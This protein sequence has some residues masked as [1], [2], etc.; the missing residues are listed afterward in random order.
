MKKNHLLVHFPKWK[1][2][3]IL[4]EMKLVLIL[5]WALSLSATAGVFSQNQRVSF[6]F[7]DATILEVLNEIKSQTGLSFI[8][9]EDKIQELN[10]VDVD[11]SG[12]TVGE[13][14]NEIFGDSN[15][16]CRFEEN[17]IMVVDKIP[18]PLI[19]VKQEKKEVKGK[20]TDD[21]GM[22][23]PGVSVVIKGT[24]TGVATDIDGN[25]IIEI[26]KSNVVLVFS[27]VGMLPQEIA[28]NGQ[29]VQ[30][31]TL[32]TDSE[33]MD[34]VVVVGYGSVKKE[35]IGSAISEIKS[36]E[37]EMKSIGVTNVE[38]MLGGN[39]KGLQI[40][41]GSGAPGAASTV[42]VRGITSPFTGGNNQPLY[43]VDGV[44]FNTDELLD[45]IL[46]SAGQNPL[47][48][49]APSE[50]K[51]ISVL[52]DAGATAIYGSRGANGVI[53]ITTKRGARDS[54]LSISFDA[55]MSISNP[56][57]E[58]DLLDA[59]EF[60]SLHEMVAKNTIDKFA[61]VN[62]RARGLKTAY[63]IID[64]STGQFK[65]TYFDTTLG[66]GVP[67]WGSANTDWQKEIYDENALTQKYN[68]SL[69][70]GNKKTNYAASLYYTDQDALM[71]NEYQKRY[72]AR[73]SFDTD[74]KKWLRMGA[75]L[76]V[77]G[78]KNFVGR[79]TSSGAGP[80]TEVLESRPDMPVYDELGRY[81]KQVDPIRISANKGKVTYSSLR[82]NPVAAS[83][84][85]NLT[86]SLSMF[87]NGYLE[88][89]PIKDLKLKTEL[90]VSNFISKAD[91]F[92]P[93]RALSYYSLF[94]ASLNV[95]SRSNSYNNVLST[96]L[97]FQ[98]NYLKVIGDHTIDVMAG[99]SSY[100]NRSE[101]ERSF[102]RDMADDEIMTNSDTGQHVKSSMGKGEAIMNSVYSRVQY[103]YNGKYTLT[104]NMRSDKSSKFGP[105]NKRGYFPSAAVNWNM[106]KE[107]FMNSL[108]FL[109][110]L[111][112]RASYGKTGLANI[113][114]FRFLQ[115]WSAPYNNE[116]Y[117]GK[118]ALAPETIYPNRDVKWETT[119]EFNT[120]IDFALFNNRLYGSVDYY[121]KRT[122]G[123][124]MPSPIFAESGASEI[125]DN[126]AEIS[127]EGMEF[128]LGGDIIRTKDLR[129]FASF[130]LAFNRN[131]LE[132]IKGNAISQWV[133]RNYVEG[134]PIGVINGLKIDKIIQ[135][136]QEI[137]ALNDAAPGDYYMDASTGVGDYLYVDTN[138]DG[139]IN[140]KDKTIIGTQEADFFGG[141]ST[142]LQYKNF[143]FTAGFQ[144]SVGNK[145]RWGNSS[146]LYLVPRTFANMGHD[147]L[148]NTWTKDNP[149]AK[150][151]R[152]AYGHR[153]NSLFKGMTNDEAVQDASYLRLKV[154]NLTY[155]F[156][157]SIT[158][159]LQLA[160]AAIY[161][162]GTNLLTFT[163]YKGLDPEAGGHAYAGAGDT[164]HVLGGVSG[165]DAYPMARTFTMGVKVRF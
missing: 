101:T 20:V 120:G 58:Y 123:A 60:K 96:T 22:P 26:E 153:N 33:Q 46:F 75:S 49:I 56:L 57:N 112:L 163:K 71:I 157:K 8:Y 42:R 136:Q 45:G 100:K 11:A 87:G 28:Y 130:N 16:E 102:F 84:N 66:K 48:A 47:E 154:V 76:S 115:F 23:L 114:D 59:K 65:D 151:P 107:E 146:N 89:K 105:G 97:S 80:V 141:F 31:V 138:K 122:A 93:V 129:W 54:K 7:E 36:E 161:L 44:A 98:A 165:N 52:K 111:K 78:G 85:R 14:L 159:K 160:G 3:K 61:T 64:Q 82:A 142:G 119:K 2:L 21:Q 134:E 95:N 92:T 35:R 19:E 15:L 147:A 155:E 91:K 148:Y 51:S 30:N 34:E 62:P 27:F 41:Q 133:I 143:T 77:S 55:S 13:V 104:L 140:S 131:V 135:S 39:I 4:L 74:I 139:Q 50:I 106:T 86:K 116:T 90:N 9:N 79:N 37:I 125:M 18:E 63:T 124:I 103:S 156:P 164:G 68:L 127:N 6:E 67:V 29:E 24:N 40:S 69:S 149:N 81:L 32:V 73:L 72:G 132:S 158:D 53:I 113:G 17:V 94:D 5:T 99:I 121:N 25:Y 12:E 144:Y 38:N 117:Q 108:A 126:R 109:N 145:K 43:V 88:V 110:N 162:G 118:I 83:E 70:G 150:Y 10:R 128:E 1:W 137:D 152:L